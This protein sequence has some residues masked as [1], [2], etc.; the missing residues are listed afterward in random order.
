MKIKNNAEV[1]ELTESDIKKMRKLIKEDG[2][3]GGISASD[4]A[5][6]V[7]DVINR[8][9]EFGLGYEL[10]LRELNS[11]FLPTK[12]RTL[13]RSQ[14]DI[15]PNPNLRISKTTYHNR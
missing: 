12:V 5:L 6:L 14:E 9:N 15:I 8:I 10:R 4:K 11:E 7:Q 1:I 13:D 3:V 2:F